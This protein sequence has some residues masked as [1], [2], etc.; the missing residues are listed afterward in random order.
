MRRQIAPLRHAGA[1]E[2]T[3]SPKSGASHHDVDLYVMLNAYWKDL[4]FTIQEG[5]PAEWR[6]VIDTSLESPEDFCE[7]GKE[8]RLTSPDYVVKARSI[9]VLIR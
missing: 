1:V 6:R 2:E 4:T 5:A 7:P 8:V 9:V 3:P